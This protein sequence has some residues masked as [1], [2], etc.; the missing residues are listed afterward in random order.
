MRW[1]ACSWTRRAGAVPQRAR[2]SDHHSAH[3]QGLTVSRHLYLGKSEGCKRDKFTS[4]RITS[5]LPSSLSSSSLSPPSLAKFIEL[6]LRAGSWVRGWIL[7]G[8]RH[9]AALAKLPIWLGLDNN[10]STLGKDQV[11][12]RSM[13]RKNASAFFQK[14]G[15]KMECSEIL[16]FCTSLRE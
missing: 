4:H 15:G 11:S 1:R 3:G 12:M 2:V 16:I 8:K 9:K 10:T 5:C 6:L 13:C 14:G 7:R